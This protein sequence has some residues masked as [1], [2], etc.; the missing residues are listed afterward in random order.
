MRCLL[1][2][3]VYSYVIRRHDP[4]LFSTM[5]TRARSGA[6]LSISASLAGDVRTRPASRC[7]VAL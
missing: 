2:T 6:E 7:P 5:P 1:D 4:R 3:D